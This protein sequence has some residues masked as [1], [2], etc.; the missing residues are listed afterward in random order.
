MKA[1]YN[2]HVNISEYEKLQHFDGADQI[3]HIMARGNLPDTFCPNQTKACL[4]MATIA[5]LNKGNFDKQSP[6]LK[7]KK[8]GAKCCR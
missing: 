1:E 5:F 4:G 6:H 7:K 3:I 2:I 8:R